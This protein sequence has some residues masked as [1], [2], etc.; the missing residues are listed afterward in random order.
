MRWLLLLAVVAAAACDEEPVRELAGWRLEVEDRPARAVSL[1]AHLDLPPNRLT[2]VLRAE[3]EVPWACPCTLVAPSLPARARLLVDGAEAVALD[4]SPADR[5]RSAGWHAW[6][7][8]RVGRGGRLALALAVEHTWQ[9]SGW[10]DVAP[11]ISPTASGDARYR[12]LV[13]FHRGAEIGSVAIILLVCAMSLVTFLLDRARVAHGW[14]ALV[15]AAVIPPVLFQFGRTQ[16]V[17]TLDIPLVLVALDAGWLATLWFVHAQFGEPP[18]SRRWL[19]PGGVALVA[20]LF[21]YEPFATAPP[22][23]AACAVV[24]WTPVTIYLLL[25]HLRRVRSPERAIRRMAR[26]QLG[27]WAIALT[28]SWI[29]LAAPVGLGQLAAGLHLA[30]LGLALFAAVESLTLAADRVRSVR[31]SEAQGRELAARME[32]LI[33]RGRELERVAEDL[34]RQAETSDRDVKRAVARLSEPPPVGDIEAGELIEGRYRVLDRLG[35]GGMGAVYRVERLRDGARLALKLLGGDPT[36]ADLA[37]F[38][39]EAEITARLQDPNIVAI[40]DVDVTGGG[41]LY[42]VMELV[43]GTSLDRARERFGAVGWAQEIIGQAARGLAVMHA[44]GIVHRDLKPANILLSGGRDA[45]LVKIA[46]FGIARSDAIVEAAPAAPIDQAGALDSELTRTGA[47]FGTPLYM[48]PELAAGVRAAPP[49]SDVFSL[50]VIAYEI[51]TGVRPFAEPPVLAR[52]KGRPLLPPHPLELG[53]LPAVRAVLIARCL[54]FAP[55]KR[56]SAAEVARGFG[57]EAP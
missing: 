15:S 41:L 22:T 57:R 34:R 9:L 5:Y 6:R 38:A 45:P 37:R 47:V 26:V 29:E 19:L 20:A 7:I 56:P 16:I 35:A 32:L 51:L 42:L 4:D 31:Q 2:Y 46:D 14:F 12:A 25:F 8:D 52:L 43:D 53:D 28:T 30:P 39:R 48:A 13:A 18:P 44:R 49:S 3:L 33:A 21:S 36:R 17:G 11:R 55:E 1:P 40:V 50:G 54:D 23:I 24:L 27:C 10:I